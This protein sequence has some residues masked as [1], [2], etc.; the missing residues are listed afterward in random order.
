MSKSSPNKLMKF[1]SL[2]SSLLPLTLAATVVHADNLIENPGFETLGDS[3]FAESWELQTAATSQGAIASITSAANSGSRALQLEQPQSIPLPPDGVQAP[4]TEKY[5]RDN[6]LNGHVLVN[7]VV[8]VMPGEKYRI[9]FNYAATGLKARD[10]HDPK[11][12][13][14]Y[15]NVQI[16][17]LNRDHRPVEGN[18][19]QLLL[20][21]DRDTEGWQEVLNGQIVDPSKIVEIP[22]IVPPDGAEFANLR[23]SLSVVGPDLTPKATFDDFVFEAVNP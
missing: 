14:A 22:P 5:I 4:N 1:R 19:V 11:T 18:Y 9:G 3:N 7:Q 2:F 8:P 15:V 6:S 17:W 20:A 13:F 21:A 10:P 16:F 23:V 12:T